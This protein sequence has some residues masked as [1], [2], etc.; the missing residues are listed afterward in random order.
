M[1]LSAG[2]CDAVPGITLAHRL[3]AEYQYY[4]W[5]NTDIW[6]RGTGPK[7]KGLPVE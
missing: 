7:A 2:L 3:T 6:V 5:E 4:L 1:L